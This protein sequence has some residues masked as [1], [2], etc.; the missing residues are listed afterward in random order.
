MKLRFTLNPPD[1]SQSYAP[2]LISSDGTKDAFYEELNALVKVVPQ[3]N[4]L[5]LLGDFNA[6]VGTECNNWKGVLGPHGTG[7]L[8]SNGFMLLSFCAENYFTITNTLFCQAD[9]YKTT[10][11]HPRS[12]QWHLS[13]HAI[14]R[15]R[16]IHDVRVTRA[17]RRIE[18]LTDHR[19]I[20]SI[21]SLHITPMRRKTAKSCRS[22]FDTA[23]LKQLQ[24]SRMFAKHLDDRLTAH[25]PL[26][27]PPPRQWEQFKTLV[28]ESAKLIIGSKKKVHQDWFAENDERIKELL[29]DKKKAFIQWQNDISS[30]SKRD[31]FKDLQRQAQ[32]AFHRMQDEWWKK[33]ANEIETYAATKN[34]KMFFS[35]INEVYGPTKSRI[36][37]LLSADD[38]TLFKESSINARWRNTSVPCSTDPT[39]WTPLCST[40]SQP[41][42]PPNDR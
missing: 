29:D 8:N 9:K 10:W 16:D 30:T 12:N 4:K 22:A 1:M 27:G 39:L 37:P 2:T 23:K 25:G 5:I 15:R 42:P 40:G 6:R 36:T 41:L 35:A 14:C 32:V 11:M 7:K 38:S 20:R 17:K 33:K 13:D 34:S 31:R 26:S 3:S 28:A 19:L 21:L 24:R 18:C